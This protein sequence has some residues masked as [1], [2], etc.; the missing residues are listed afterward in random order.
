METL[1]FWSLPVIVMLI[2]LKGEMMTAWRWCFASTAALYVGVWGAPAWWGLL[3]FLPDG[4]VAYRNALA[5]LVTAAA[6]FLILYKTSTAISPT[7]HDETY[8]F[9]K[10]AERILNALFRLV[11]GFALSTLIF[12]L[13]CTTPLKMLV[14]GGEKM[15]SR[16]DAALLKFTLIAD[17]LTFS[18]AKTPREK[19]LK[20]LKLWYEPPKED[21][22][23][24]P[25]TATPR[26]AEPSKT[27]AA[28]PP[29]KAPVR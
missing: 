12:V 6:V 20:T 15:Q 25:K 23:E 22:A 7:S 28:A 26:L 5:I 2:G 17:R 14:R 8:T 19:M 21:K 11:T 27:P 29:A 24:A 4:M 10:P 9:P 18:S 3:D 1:L 16:T 13:C